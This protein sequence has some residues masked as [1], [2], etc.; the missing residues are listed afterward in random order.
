MIGRFYSPDI[1]SREERYFE[2]IVVVELTLCNIGYGLSWSRLYEL[3]LYGMLQD[4]IGDINQFPLV[5]SFV[6]HVCRQI[7]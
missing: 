5:E 4:G 7:E 2:E 3:D 1:F 6:C